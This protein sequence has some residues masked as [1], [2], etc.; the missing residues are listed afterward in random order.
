MA[1]PKKE[2]LLAR[3]VE[4]QRRKRA[5]TRETSPYYEGPQTRHKK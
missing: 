5:A 2:E 4:L 1:E 3:Y